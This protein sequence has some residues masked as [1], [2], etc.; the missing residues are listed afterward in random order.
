MARNLGDKAL[1]L[2]TALIVLYV[3]LPIIFLILMSFKS[4]S[5]ISFPIEGFTLFWYVGPITMGLQGG[6]INDPMMMTSLWNSFVVASISMAIG[7]LL[8]IGTG[9]CLRKEFRL[10][11]FV[12][13]LLLLGMMTPGVIHGIS[14]LIVIRVL[15]IPESPVI[16]ALTHVVWAVPFGILLLMPRFDPKLTRYEEAAR[17]LGA[18]EWQVFKEITFPLISSPAI[19]VMLFMFTL[20][21]GELLR[22]AFVTPVVSPTL[23]VYIYSQLT[24]QPQ[25]PKFY[26]VGTTVAAISIVLMTLSGVLIT[27][28]K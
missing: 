23:P 10:K 16:T 20:S 17:I 2:Y 13:F 11:N 28:K 18:T 21:W 24:S 9:L 8:C 26:A 27:R 19:G 15:S 1:S 25:T 22:S 5:S 7:S 3:Y 4:G 6:F 12:F 14:T